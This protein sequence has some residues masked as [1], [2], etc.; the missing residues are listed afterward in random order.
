M[1]FL[2]A[3]L[4][5]LTF[6][7]A[8]MGMETGSPTLTV[9]REGEDLWSLWVTPRLYRLTSGEPAALLLRVAAPDGWMVVEI[10]AG[11]GAEGM[12]LTH[13]DLPAEEVKILLD[14]RLSMEAD[15]AFLWVRME[16]NNENPPKQ[17]GYMDVTGGERGKVSL[18]V[19]QNDGRVEEITMAV[20][21]DPSG[22]N[23][24]TEAASYEETTAESI[25]TPAET[26][27]EAEPPVYED[28]VITPLP[29]VFVGCRETEVTEGGFAVQFLFK[30]RKG[31]TPVICMEGGGMLSAASGTVR[32]K[33]ETWH[34]CTFFGLRDDR[35]YVFLVGT[36]TG[37]VKVTYAGGKFAG[38]R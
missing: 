35:V 21:M 15:G 8:A 34:T 31:H 10:T 4:W 2:L 36:D 3:G 9:R 28:P 12:I 30:G 32:M 26:E 17:G 25:Q 6:G 20:R 11:Y 16:K 29:S 18:F 13:G 37:W 38:F 23:E 14:G 33:G 1:A 27:T 24:D 7:V 19:L 22:W 5:V